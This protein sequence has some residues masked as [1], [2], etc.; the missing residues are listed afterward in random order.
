[1]LVQVR[2]RVRVGVDAGSLRS[3]P[4]LVHHVV[5]VVDRAPVLVDDELVDGQAAVQDALVD[6]Q[7]Q[8]RSNV[9]VQGGGGLRTA[10]LLWRHGGPGQEEEVTGRPQSPARPGS[11]QGEPE[12]VAPSPPDRVVHEPDSAGSTVDFHASVSGSTSAKCSTSVELDVRDAGGVGERVGDGAV[13]IDGDQGVLGALHDRRPA[14]RRAAGASGPPRRTPPAA[15]PATPPRNS[16]AAPLPIPVR[17]AAVRSATGA[18]ATIRRTRVG[19]GG[20]AAPEREVAAGGVTGEGVRR[21]GVDESRCDSLDQAGHLA[22]RCRDVVA[23]PGPG[24]GSATVLRERDGEPAVDQRVGHRAQV[25]AVPLLVPE[26]AMDRDHE[27]VGVAGRPVLD[28]RCGRK[29][30]IRPQS[31]SAYR[32]T[33]S[34]GSAARVSTSIGSRSTCPTLAI[35]APAGLPGEPCTWLVN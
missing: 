15:R 6:L 10:E 18:S 17:A 16:T 26:A 8:S 23:G 21:R 31:W 25:R 4:R 34:G 11:A 20:Q 5:R 2:R 33:A 22:E 7:C 24:G 28:R 13:G 12:D 9:R 30:S 29:R 14:R 32:T 1:M 3:P 19:P 27:P 35:A